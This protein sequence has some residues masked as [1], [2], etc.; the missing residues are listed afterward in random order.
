[1]LYLIPILILATQLSC[2][3]NWL[4]AKPSK[5]LIVPNSLNDYQQI[6]DNTNIFNNGLAALS[7]INADNYYTTYA[8][9][10]SSGSAV[11]RNS[12]TWAKDLFAG[13]TVCPD[14]T[15]A[16]RNILYANIIIEGLTK[17]DAIPANE[18]EYN[19]I[20]GGALFHRAHNLYNLAQLFCPP[21]HDQNASNQAGLP[22]RTNAKV[23]EP[24]IRANLKTTY[25]QI[26]SDLS[27]ASALLPETQPYL[28]RPSK[29]AA[30]AMLARVNLAIG[31]YKKALKYADLSLQ[32]NHQLLEFSSLNQTANFPFTLFN[33]EV[34]FH[35]AAGTYLILS[36]VRFNVDTTLYH[37]YDGN[38]LRKTCYYKLSGTE[39]KFKGSYV[40]NNSFFSGLAV[41]EML[42]IRAEC[43]ARANNTIAAM[44]DLNTLLKTRWKTENGISTFIDKNAAN[45]GDALAMILT[46]RRKELPFRELRWTDLRRLN[47]M[48]AH[49]TT[50]TR[51]LNG[52]S[53][54]LPPNDSRYTLPIPPNE[55]TSSG[56]EQNQR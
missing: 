39:I 48:P 50:L 16:Y 30:Y 25:D 3:K 6:L 9:W 2:K 26:T 36:G 22:I 49:A 53:Y 46:E 14:W 51:L 7:E 54:S 27:N 11:E 28:T 18:K 21:Y 10:Q 35:C 38:D 17:I 5:S 4:E 12:Y 31:N 1:M 41:D 13:E 15:N 56:I 33:K 34:I 55:I 52:I 19:S 47:Q 29:N 40:G 44:S 42:L 37:S 32:L 45:A 24:V 43:Q 23:N 8:N 20:R